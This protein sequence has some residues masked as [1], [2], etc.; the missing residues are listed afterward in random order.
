MCLGGE[1]VLRTYG[2][3]GPARAVIERA[4]DAGMTYCDSARAYSG[5][6][7]YYGAFWRDNP[8]RR[9]SI[10]QTS[11]SARRDRRGA[12]A[13]L[14]RTL[15]T[16]NLDRLDL[17]QI[18]DVRTEEDIR[19]LEGPGGALEAFVTAKDQGMT[20]FIGVTG[21]EDPSVLTHAVENWPVDT[22]LLPA[23]PVEGI[24]G[25]FLSETLP[26]AK[27]RGIGVIGMKILGA[28]TYIAP[29]L[30]IT[31]EILVRYALSHEI[32]LGIVGCSS[33]AEVDALAGVARDFLPLPPVE[34]HV[35]EDQFRPSV[36]RLAYYRSVR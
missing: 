18:H 1:G 13:D 22:V 32:D 6:E 35:L 9:Q 19:A 26:A 20:R 12:L 7:G 2:Q 30:G 28:G 16:M 36:E 5:S 24:L 29:D 4:A 33:P 8:G 17:W 3:D 10:F 34:R 23:N 31:P 27:K 21:H 15:T 25:G 11:K 14:E